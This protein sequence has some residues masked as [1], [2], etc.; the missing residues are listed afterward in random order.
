MN[1]LTDLKDDASD[2]KEGRWIQGSK[3]SN[4]LL[5]LWFWYGCCGLQGLGLSVTVHAEQVLL[6]WLE[7][8][9]GL[10]QTQQLAAQSQQA[11]YKE[12]SEKGDLFNGYIE[13]TN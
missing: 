1:D 4:F 9:A 5:F 12:A 13:K 2:D 6:E 8:Q 10:Q 7:L 3:F 11:Y